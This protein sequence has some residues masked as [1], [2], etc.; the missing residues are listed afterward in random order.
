MTRYHAYYEIDPNT[1]AAIIEAGFML[2]D[3]EL[4]TE[5]SDRVARGIVNGLICFI[6]GEGALP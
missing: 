3:R 5:Q 6:E 4:L 1:P 2:E